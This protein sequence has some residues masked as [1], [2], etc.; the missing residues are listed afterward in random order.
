MSTTSEF[1]SNKLSDWLP[2]SLK[3]A[4][5]RGWDGFDVILISGDAYVDHPSFGAAVIG[6]VIEKEG[7]RIGIIPQPNWQDDLRDFKKLGK[8]ELFFAVTSGC[9]DSM[10]NHYTAARRLRSNDAYTPGGKPGFRPDRATTVYSRILKQL[11]PETPVII[12]GIEASLR[13]LTHYDYWADTLH[14]SILAD[15]AADL[16]VYGMGEQPMREIL[17]LLSRGVPFSSLKTI[18]QTA[19]L[20]SEDEALPRNKN[21]ETVELSPHEE[22]LREK[23]RFAE[24]FKK[25]ENEAG[26]IHARRLT[27]K[28]ENRTVVVNPHFEPAAE[29]EMDYSFDLP[30]TRQPHPRYGKKEPI[31]AFKMIQFSVT[32][33]RGCFGGCSFCAINA[34]QGKTVVSR[35][36]AS[37]QNE[38]DRI[39]R[40][41]DFAGIISDLGG[42][43]ANMYQMQ[44]IDKNVCEKCARP[45]CVY[46]SICFNL[47][48]NHGPL[49]DIYKKASAHPK[50]KKIFVNSG[51]RYDL[52]LGRPQKETLENKCEEYL[53]ELVTNH[54]SGR[55]KVAP[56]HSSDRVLK[57]MR[58][59]GF[60]LFREFKKRFDEISAK[61]GKRQEI[62]PYFI[63]GHPGCD[64]EDMAELAAETKK[65]GFKP[66][67]VQDFT[68]TPMTLAAVIYY[69]GINPINGK[70]VYT[71]RTKEEKLKQNRFFF[72]YKKENQ[73]WIRDTLSELKR[74]DLKEIF[75]SRPPR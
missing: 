29:T 74:A 7:Y 69:S 17:K 64:L 33:H 11:F 65:L 57:Y 8:P 48:T 67:Q 72:W 66:E 26:K 31:P 40:E 73:K 63:S 36:P 27:Q 34:H 6:R 68:P 21:W 70:K 22:C 20:L 50:I 55:L 43:S 9:M 42:P 37:I 46:P 39:S 47:N 61:K 28:I 52:F 44:G 62:V 30:Y 75:T 54:V 18:P 51:L 32:T 12:G 13:R 59:P 23:S 56:E 3:E 16:L 41:P 10:I 1:R 24:N 49:I 58:K 4:N 35:S 15:S 71:A 38:V 19:F 45:S 25:I 14:P 53:E 5:I 2:V 60:S